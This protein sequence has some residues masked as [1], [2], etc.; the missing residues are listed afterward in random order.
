LETLN[1]DQTTLDFL[2]KIERRIK[3]M[4]G[5]IPNEYF[6]FPEEEDAYIRSLRF[7]SIPF[8]CELLSYQIP[9]GDFHH[10]HGQSQWKDS[11][12]ETADNCGI[13]SQT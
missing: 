9:D 4:S 5:G 12:G 7:A 10:F 2:A 3:L 11:K 6:F 1:A 13:L 8:P